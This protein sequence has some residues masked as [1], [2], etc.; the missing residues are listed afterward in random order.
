MKLSKVAIENFR[1]YRDKTE[2]N[3]DNLTAI[4]GKNDIGKSTILEALE[5]FFNNSI[6]TC[7][8]NDLSVNRLGNDENI[9][10]TCTFTDLPSQVTIDAAF[11][12]SLENEFLL[13]EN[14]E[15][16]ILKIFKATSAKPKE[17]VFIRCLHPSDTDYSDLLTLKNA[18][19][20]KRAE[21]LKI[22]K[23][24]YNASINAEIRQ[25]I[26]LTNKNCY[27]E[28]ILI[29]ADK[30]DAKKI[31]DNLKL[32]LPMYALF[33]SDRS[34][35]DDDNEITD[36]M[37]IAIQ[38]A[39][40]EVSEELE[41]IKE[42]VRQRTL[43]TAIRTLEKLK[44][45]SPDLANSLVPE[46]KSEPKFDSLFKLSINSD[47]NIPINKRGSGVRRLI[48]LNFFR[49]EAER[50]L[51]ESNSSSIIYAFEEPETSQH[52]D[53]QA[54]L[55]EAFLE[56]SHTPNTQII[57]TTHTP[58]LASMI[59]IE[60]LRFLSKSNDD[61]KRIVMSNSDTTYELICNELGVLPNPINMNT[62][63]IIL[64]EG[65]GDVIFLNHAAQCL[66]K[67]GFLETTFEKAN[68][69][70]VPIGGCGTLKY[71]IN[72]KLID[73][74]YLPWGILLDSDNGAAEQTYN[75]KKV[76]ELRKKGIKA[77]T[78]RKREPENYIH[79]DCVRETVQYSDT[80]DAKEII[81]HATN[82]GKND[83]LIKLWPKMTG[84]RIREVEKYEDNG[85]IHYELTEMITD[86]LKLMS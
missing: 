9:K 31:Y 32:Y 12:T 16:E 6:V 3:F 77:Y 51:K 18:D 37:K 70:I 30:E 79:Y 28:V 33:Q 68:F 64:V 13:N 57:L 72:L 83:V 48:L 53:H 15:L 71:W 58:A 25:A 20:K 55:V 69:A 56:L 60:N 34:S 66:Y 39:L 8:K 27:K 80:D 65:P 49:A 40:I 46:F 50:R 23:E 45:M 74:F 54:L 11:K 86:F 67:D 24:S 17:S 19:L 63:A 59:N 36:P 35:T 29:P 5:I 81:N 75:F 38:Q 76:S 7:D 85:I 47:N 1:A 2:I 41:N 61:E 52:P 10:I 73:Q 62:R 84:A 82:I 14:G 22:S 42:A 21:S 43:D 4:I 78:T 26:R 44:E